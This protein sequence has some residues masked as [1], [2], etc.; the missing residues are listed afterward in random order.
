MEH[1]DRT[2][3]QRGASAGPGRGGSSGKGAGLGKHPLLVALV[4]GVFA[5]GGTIGAAVIVTTYGIKVEEGCTSAVNNY[6]EKLWD[7]EGGWEGAA[8]HKKDVLAEATRD[9]VRCATA[10]EKGKIVR[11]LY[12]LGALARRSS[13]MDTTNLDLTGAD[14]RGAHL[15]EVSL[16]GAYLE[17]AD[18][19][20]RADLTDADLSLVHANG[21]DLRCA[22]AAG[23]DLSG[24]RLVNADLR[25]AVLSSGIVDAN[26]L[27]MDAKIHGAKLDNVALSAANGAPDTMEGV[28]K[29]Q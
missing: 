24:A 1:N 4:G 20:G 26:T 15:R 11:D 17:N 13:G 8:K 14:L 18:L 16:A 25:Y 27:I 12:A 23:I 21:V 28:V 9:A 3:D 7:T 29:C 6:I 22:N 2:E 19:S 10:E 5:A